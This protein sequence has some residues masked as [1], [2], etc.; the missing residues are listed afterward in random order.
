MFRIIAFLLLIVTPL[1]AI[2]QPTGV[3]GSDWDQPQHELVDFAL[4]RFAKAGLQLPS[5]L[6]IDFPTDEAKCFGYGGLYLPEQIEV[7]ICRPSDT[8]IVH[9]FAHAWIETTLTESERQAFLEL[10]GLDTWVGGTE[11]GERGAEQAAEILTW[12]VMDRDITVRWLEPGPNNTPVETFRLFKIANST[13]GD[14]TEAYR[15]LT[16]TDPVDRNAQSRAV[17]T[18]PD[19]SSPE[20]RRLGPGHTS[21]VGG[22]RHNGVIVSPEA[23]QRAFGSISWTG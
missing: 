18:G 6:E 19:L 17:E 9:E 1:Q 5:E 20:A 10:R 16:D 11:W 12:A 21:E 15:L 22:L 3:A 14:L 8:T 7:R 4:E 2:G 23:V 13:H